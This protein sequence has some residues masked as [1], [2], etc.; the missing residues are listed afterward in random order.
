M[1]HIKIIVDHDKIDYSG[2]LNVTELLKLIEGFIWERG[3]DKRQDKD[4]EQNTDKGKFVEWQ[5]SPWKW[6]SDYT[7]FII[8]VRV[9]GY[10][11][12]KADAV[13][14]KKKVKVDSGRVIIVID[15]FVESDLQSKWEQNH[16]MHLIRAVYDNFIHKVYTER[17][18]QIII[19]DINHLHSQIEKFLNMYR[20]YEVISAKGP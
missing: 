2:P 15:G 20:H 9:I 11:I 16:F 7:R 4:F 14:D 13:Q 19:H 18:E 12:V 8:K 17:F 3:F 10:D 6:I 5:I 1:G